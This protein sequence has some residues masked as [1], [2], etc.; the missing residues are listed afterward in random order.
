M[1]I[2][3]EKKDNDVQERS[4]DRLIRFVNYLQDK[5][6]IK[7]GY[8]FEKRCNLSPRYIY[9]VIRNKSGSLGSDTIARICKEFPE[10]NI[11]WLC[12]GIGS[13]VLLEDEV[14]AH[15]KAAYDAACKEIEA[16]REIIKKL[17][18]A[19]EKGVE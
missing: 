17:D 10:L 14:E 6:V 15:Y 4:I 13:M 11:K 7:N 2:K 18:A 8:D 16:L 9:H 5:K 19:R 3:W 1:S 12:M